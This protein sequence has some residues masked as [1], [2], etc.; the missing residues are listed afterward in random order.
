VDQL[1]RHF[2]LGF[3]A[4]LPL[5]NPL[6]SALVFLGFVGIQPASVY[7]SLARQIAIDMVLFF[8][9]IELIG[10]FLLSFFGIS[11]PIVQFAG[12]IVVA[13]I[14]WG[15]LNQSDVDDSSRDP[16]AETTKKA[17][18]NNFESSAFYPLTFPVTAGP[19][20]LVVMLTLS[21]HTM[22]G[23][24]SQTVL[25]R[26][27]LMLAVI[28]LA[29]LVYLCY[30]YAPQITRT[31]SPS[32]VHGILRVIAFILLCIGVQIAWNGLEALIKPLLAH[33]G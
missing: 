15:L 12:G 14:G 3:S 9:V 31:I 30:A 33:H 28:L 6:G 19:G 29:V 18:S 13:A 2:A 8:A 32:T 27:G 5:V 24:L 1:W 4:L 11:L 10:S 21:A 23:N 17:A 25:A 26:V 20:C 22:G 7:K 16:D